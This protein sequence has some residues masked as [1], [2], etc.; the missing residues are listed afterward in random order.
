[1]S[2]RDPWDKVCEGMDDSPGMHDFVI[3]HGIRSAAMLTVFDDEMADMLAD[4]LAPRIA[5]KVVVEVGGGLGL[6]GCHMAYHAERVYCIE[7]NPI[8]TAGFVAALIDK[9]PKNL[10]YLFGSADQFYGL[11]RAH[12][13]LFC[14]H[15]GVASMREAAGQFA[16]TVIDVWGDLIA[17]KPQCF[18]KFA[19][20]A[21]LWA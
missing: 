12:V 20:K 11:L 18:D 2:A 1:M 3:R 6:L 9:K 19:A 14:T 17:E 16:P 21:R 5:G 10:S 13:A 4:Y 15:S 7:A 8:W